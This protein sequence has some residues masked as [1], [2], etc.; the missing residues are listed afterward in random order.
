MGID[1]LS[2]ANL[3]EHK[4]VLNNVKRIWLAIDIATSKMLMLHIKDGTK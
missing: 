3:M 2:Y 1:R 4:I